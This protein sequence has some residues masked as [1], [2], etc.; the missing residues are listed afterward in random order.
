MFPKCANG[1]VYI[2]SC[3]TAKGSLLRIHVSSQLPNFT[4]N[5]TKEIITANCIYS[6]F[7]W[8]TLVPCV[9]FSAHLLSHVVF[10]NPLPTLVYVFFLLPTYVPGVCMY[11]SYPLPTTTV[12]VHLYCH[13]PGPPIV[14]GVCTV[15]CLTLCPPFVPYRYMYNVTVSDPLPTL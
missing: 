8:P 7:L 2:Y 4:H 1:F 3:C 11:I 14:L 9:D 5:K 13:S 15:H 6:I 10:S 12:C